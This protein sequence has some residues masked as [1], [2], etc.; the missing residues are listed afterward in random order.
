MSDAPQVPDPS[1]LRAE[2]DALAA[3]LESRSSV[4]EARKG[5]VMTFL[6]ILG[7]GTCGALAWDRYG[8]LRPGF[9]RVLPPGGPFFL[10]LAGV[11]TATV[12]AIATGVLLRARRLGREEAVLAT[13]MLEL[14]RV[15][16]LEP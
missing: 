3:R 7:V 5:L 11:I 8:P 4:D 14:R 9:V 16:E 13:R 2:H 15:L 6:A 10:I 12:A 1:A